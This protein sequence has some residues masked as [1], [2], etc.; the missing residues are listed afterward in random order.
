[1]LGSTIGSFAD[2]S[3]ARSP[4]TESTIERTNTRERWI[5]GGFSV[6]LFLVFLFIYTHELIAYVRFFCRAVNV[7]MLLHDA[8]V[9]LPILKN[10]APTASMSYMSAVHDGDP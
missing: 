10:R 8:R 6:L 9:R 5:L 4:V 3:L 1:L 7:A 2:Q